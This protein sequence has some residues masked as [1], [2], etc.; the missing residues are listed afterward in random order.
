LKEQLPQRLDSA[1]GAPKTY[2]IAANLTDFN[3][4][5]EVW[6]LEGTVGYGVG[7]Q[8]VHVP[9]TGVFHKRKEGGFELIA[10]GE[11]SGS[12]QDIRFT[13]QPGHPVLTHRDISAVVMTDS[14]TVENGTPVQ[15]ACGILGQP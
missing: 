14:Q 11:L 2:E 10:S 3:A 8:T 7:S 6:D 13:V 1:S 12:R 5:L 9:I 15:A 4:D